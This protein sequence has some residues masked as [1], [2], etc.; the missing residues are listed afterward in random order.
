M[1]DASPSPAPGQVIGPVLGTAEPLGRRAAVEG[2]GTAL[3][4]LLASL[5]LLLTGDS[6]LV[7][8]LTVAF[9][10]VALM[11]AFARV[12]GGHFNPAVSL[13]VALSGRLSWL[14]AGVYAV[15]QLVGGLLGASLAFLV[16]VQLDD[17][18]RVVG[19]G[20]PGWG[21]SSPL[22]SGFGVGGALLLELL[23]VLV[24]VLVFLGAT[25]RRQASPAL[26]PVVVGLAYGALHLSS[27]LLTGGSGNPARA[28]G[29]AVYSDGAL[30]QVWLF[31]LVPLVAAGLAGGLYLLLAG[32][33][34]EAVPGSGLA[35]PERQPAAPGRRVAGAA[36]Q[37]GQ[38][39]HSGATQGAS[40][41]GWAPAAA[42][43]IQDGWQWDPVA[44]QWKPVEQAPPA[45]PQTQPGQVG[46]GQPGQSGQ[47]G[48]DG[49]TQIRP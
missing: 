33:D 20:A 49:R 44:H 26:A 6:G 22:G 30:G 2:V 32:A 7:G 14:D 1:S 38:S 35:L 17:F 37:P 31:V 36:G 10:V 4:V 16:M 28:L 21:E 5:G 15:V 47:T 27:G 40:G 39:G 19:L 24:L 48:D 9:T 43:I 29:A 42:P 41:Q 13:G 11:A 8:A 3:L 34:G 18:S 12:S 45:A 25:D 23:L 46:Y